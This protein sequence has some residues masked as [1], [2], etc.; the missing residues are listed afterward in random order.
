[1]PR[2]YLRAAAIF[3]PRSSRWSGAHGEAITTRPLFQQAIARR[4]R[5][6]NQTRL[7]ISSI[8]AK[9]KEAAHLLHRISTWLKLFVQPAEQLGPKPEWGAMLRRIFQDFGKF[10][11]DPAPEEGA[12][13]PVNCRI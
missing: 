8:H 4:T 12:L 13:V 11:F 10:P 1:M 7:Y 5:H 6:A 3:I 2:R 9:A